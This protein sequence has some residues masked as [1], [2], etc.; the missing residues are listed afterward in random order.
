M[1]STKI[2]LTSQA[3]SINHYKNLKGEIL[4]RCENIYFIRPCLK[5][6]LTPNYVKIN[7]PY[8]SLTT[9][10]TNKK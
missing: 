8:T 1:S 6:N 4:K 9:I 2:I 5:M 3:R 7:I 10:V